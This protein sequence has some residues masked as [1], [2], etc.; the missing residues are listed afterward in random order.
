MAA[1]TMVDRKIIVF[2]LNAD[3][4]GQSPRG[5]FPISSLRVH[6]SVLVRPFAGRDRV[7][8]IDASVPVLLRAVGRI[9]RR[10]RR[11]DSPRRVAIARALHRRRNSR[12]R[13]RRDRP[14]SDGPPPRPDE[15]PAWQR[16]RWLTGRSLSFL[17]MLM[18]AV[19]RH[20]DVFQYLHYEFISPFWCVHLRGAIVSWG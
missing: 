14:R 7:V 18:L 2:S 8:G 16:R 1:A 20:G 10:A 19:N 15:R 5:R 4:G 6:I 11:G 9:R 3:A 12:A 17:S 13:S